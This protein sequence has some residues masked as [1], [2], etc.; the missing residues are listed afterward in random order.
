MVKVAG[1][2][3]RP[4]D[5]ETVLCSHSAVEQAIVTLK[6]SPFGSPRLVAYVLHRAGIQ[7]GALELARFLAPRI[8]EHMMPAAFVILDELPVTQNGKVRRG[9]LPEPN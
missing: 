3:V 7:V 4:H 1:L 9:D 5:I 2:W 6:T 8:A